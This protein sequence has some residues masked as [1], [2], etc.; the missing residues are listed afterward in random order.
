MQ[1]VKHMLLP[2]FFFVFFFDL[3]SLRNAQVR[4]SPQSVKGETEGLWTLWINMAYLPSSA[5]SLVSLVDPKTLLDR[6]DFT[7]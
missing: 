3:I 1:F 4:L 7:F 6:S 5:S 2:S